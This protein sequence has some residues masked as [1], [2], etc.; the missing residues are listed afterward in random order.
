MPQN[1]QGS[2]GDLSL[3]RKNVID[4]VTTLFVGQLGGRTAGLWIGMPNQHFCHGSCS[5]VVQI[6]RRPPHF[7][8]GG[9][10]KRFAGIQTQRNVRNVLFQV[11][12]Q[13]SWVATRA[14]QLGK[15]P[16]SPI[17]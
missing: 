12:K 8:Q 3:Q 11:R 15:H 14:A 4:Q 2:F 7:Y 5:T 13:W 17:R 9:R 1:P 16:L 6:G 10:V